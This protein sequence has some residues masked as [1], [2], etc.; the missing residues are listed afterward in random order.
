MP[1][2][3]QSALG[4]VPKLHLLMPSSTPGEKPLRQLVQSKTAAHAPARQQESLAPT[5]MH[6]MNCEPNLSLIYWP[7]T[8]LKLEISFY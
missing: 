3:Q 1:E 2:R 7:V 5:Y 4:R 6:V 8:T